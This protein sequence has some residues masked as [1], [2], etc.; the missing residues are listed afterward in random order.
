MKDFNITIH[1]LPVPISISGFTDGKFTDVNREWLNLMGFPDSDHVLGKTSVELGFF[2]DTLSRNILLDEIKSN[3][4]FRNKEIW[5]K[6]NDNSK[7]CLLVNAQEIFFSGGHYI[8]TTYSDITNRIE[9]ESSLKKSEAQYRELVDNAR[10]IILKMDTKGRFTFV[11]EFAQ[12]FFGYSQEELLGK[13]AFE[14]VV[15]K[16]ESTGRHLEEMINNIYKDPDKFSVNVNENILKNGERVWIEWYNKALFDDRG[17]RIGHMAIGFDITER[18]KNQDALIIAREKLSI[19]LENANIGLWEWDFSKNELIWDERSERIFGL[20]PGSF[21][22]TLDA[23]EELVVE[24]DL[25]HIRDAT[26]NSIENGVPYETVFRIRINNA[27]RWI[28]SK[29]FIKSEFDGKPRSMLGVCLDITA[30]RE[31]TDK[32]IVRLNDELLRSNKEL[33]NFAYVASH[34][35]QEPLRMVTSFTQLLQK[36]YSDKLDADANTYIQYAVDGSKHMYE[37]LNG[38]LAFSRIKTSGR[39]F[40]RVDMNNVVI[41]VK[42]NLRL[43]LT[44]KDVTI[45]VSKLPVIIADENQMIQLIQN[46]VVNGIKYNT[47]K[48]VISISSSPV[49]DDFVFSVK[50]NG[51]GIEPQYFEKIF[52]IFQRLHTREQ[53]EGTGIGLS[54]CKRIVERHKGRIWVESKPGEGSVFLFSLPK[55][56]QEV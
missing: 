33:E 14:T 21:R 35:L 5:F 22:R 32:A 40:S 4:Y 30:L 27:V 37:L 46:L 19:A 20:T 15:P 43:K 28:S 6:R 48:P 53:I 55:D 8:L 12:S 3:G 13:T 41:K 24:E 7:L 10:T 31:D 29:A 44:E 54:I 26:K 1:E 23:F 36:R 51:I 49:D 52:R 39:E 9:A 47:G 50:D 25:E 11:N 45:N 17:G 38:L 42:E 34:D 2:S 18:K 16:Q 56:L